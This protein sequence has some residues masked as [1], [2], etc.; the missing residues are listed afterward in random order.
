[1]SMSESQR[2]DW[3]EAIELVEE[4]N[5]CGEWPSNTALVD[6][7]PELAAR[8]ANLETES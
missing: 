6:L 5:E 2:R 4:A 1:M 8:V 3:L 7:L